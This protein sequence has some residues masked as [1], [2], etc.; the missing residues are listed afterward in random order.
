MPAGRFGPAGGPGEWSGLPDRQLAKRLSREAQ[1]AAKAQARTQKA[2]DR[3]VARRARLLAKARRALPVQLVVS[4]GAVVTTVVISGNDPFWVVGAVAG[5]MAAT[6]VSRLRR[7]PPVPTPPVPALPPLPPPPHP[8]SA[9]FPAV[10]RLEAVREEL[11]RLLPLVA[12]AGR[13]AATEAWQAAAEADVA[14]R[15]QASRL[16][17]VEPHRGVDAQLLA[18]LEAGVV[19]QERVVTAVADLVAASADPLATGR[20][21]DATDRVSGLAQ[22]LREVR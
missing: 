2:Y 20:L 4:A 22:G 9:A 21:Q 6:S 15:W 16:A 10:R 7:P 18:Q 17:A 12:P 14:L 19:A 8:R 3:A 5:A 11:R 13:D 1:L